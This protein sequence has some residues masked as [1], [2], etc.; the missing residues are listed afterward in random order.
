MTKPIV[1]NGSCE[2]GAYTVARWE[3]IEDM[4]LAGM[5]QAKKGRYFETFRRDMES[6]I[7]AAREGER[8][9]ALKVARSL[10]DKVDAHERPAPR[11]QWSPSVMGA[12]P[13]IG[14]YLAG[15]PECMRM[16]QVQRDAISPVNVYICATVSGGASNDL[17]AARAAAAMALCMRISETRPSRLYVVHELGDYRFAGLQVVELPPTSDG[18]FGGLCAALTNDGLVRQAA[19]HAIYNVVGREGFGA[20]AWSSPCPTAQNHIACIRQALG[21]SE[22]DF[23]VPG[24]SIIESNEMMKDPVSWVQKQ[25]AKLDRAE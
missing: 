11:V 18:D 19:F 21:M 6:A 16:R 5:E 4:A 12:Y 25:L 20:W 10:A 15:M 22:D 3:T 17:I 13:M 1:T 8:G 14:D 23:Y 9:N 24:G 7:K 2:L